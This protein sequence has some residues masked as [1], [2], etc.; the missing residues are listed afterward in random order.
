[1]IEFSTWFSLPLLSSYQLFI[2][3]R[4]SVEIAKCTVTYFLLKLVRHGDVF[5]VE[6]VKCT[7]QLPTVETL[8]R[9]GTSFGRSD[10]WDRLG[11]RALVM[12]GQWYSR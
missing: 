11:G 2:Q 4:I 5:P 3:K 7:V 9:M 8:R 6:I 10:F 1:M 12:I